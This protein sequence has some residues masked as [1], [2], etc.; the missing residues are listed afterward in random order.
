MDGDTAADRALQHRF[1]F[2]VLADCHITEGSGGEHQ[3]RLD[4]AVSWIWENAAERDI[5]LV[6]VLGD[7]AWNEGFSPAVASLSALPLPWVPI[8]GDNEIQS[9]DEA[10]FHAAFAPQTA[11][12]ADS[13]DQW[14]QAPTPVPNPQRGGESAFQN[15]GFDFGGLRFLGVDWSSREIGGVYSETP[16]LHDFPGGTWPWLRGEL[17]QLQDRPESS[18][19]LLSH[20]PLFDGPGGLTVDEVPVDLDTLAP[21]RDALWAN[22]AGHLHGDSS[23]DWEEAGIEV[24]VTDATWDDVVTVNVVEVRGDDRG[25]AFVQERVVVP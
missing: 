25:F 17:A 20:M 15:L 16:D 24:H 21:H 13:L 12:L 23:M 3:A 14:T 6:V 19:V 1:A 22:L 2:A 5:Q 7:I 18:V 4:R 11:A 9:L 8:L 10:A